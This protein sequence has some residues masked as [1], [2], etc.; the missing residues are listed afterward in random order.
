MT[1]RP[2]ACALALGLITGLAAPHADAQTRRATPAKSKPA[3]V[4]PACTDFYSHANAAWMLANPL[5]P[6]AGSISA[7]GQLGDRARAQQIALL[8]ASMQAPQNPLQTLLGDF[9][10]SGLNEP[11]VENDGANPIA[12]LLQRVDAIKRTA[13]IAP[14]IAALHQVGIP[15]AF[16]FG[17]DIDLQDLNR[18]IGYLSQ[19]GLGLPDPA[20]YTRTDAD[21]RALLAQ[22]NLYVQKIL[23][24][25]GVP[26]DKLAAQ[27][28][29]VIDLETR[30]AQVAK[31]LAQ[32][33]DPRANYAPVA[34]N[35]LDAQYRNLQLGQFLKVQ[36]LSYDSGADAVIS[37]S[38]PAVLAQ[39][40]G[41]V[42][43]LKPE[44][45]RAYLRWRIGDAMAP[46]LAK[47]WRDAHF[48]FRGRLLAGRAAPAP[49][50]QQVL[51]AINLAAGPM[52]GR[53]Y[54][55]SY[56]P[57]ATRARAQQIADHVRD[58][59]GAALQRDTRLGPQAKA[60]AQSKLSKLGIEI[61]A[62]ARDLD[63]TV[64]PM[65]RG[66]FGGNMLIASAWRHR[67]EMKRIGR[68]NADRRWDVLPQQPA[69]AYEVA[70]NRL[71]V[72]AAMLQPPVLDMLK[73]DAAQYGAF[74]ALV[75]HELSHGF[76]AR[77][78]MVDSS[79]TLRDW[80]SPADRGAWEAL[81]NRVTAQYG[82]QP[83]LAGAKPNGN[84]TRDEN[85]A[86]I[87]GVEL[88]WAAFRGVQPGADKPS[89][90][91][92]YEG[93]AHLWPQHMSP[94]AATLRAASGVHSP[95]IWRTNGPLLNQAGFGEAFSCKPGTPMQPKVDEQIALWR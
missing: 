24:L 92:F 2:L 18:H 33:R 49:R 91:A 50:Q 35:G 89:Q 65:G 28:Q 39:L 27:A 22:Y 1:L 47:A 53:E 75:G 94:E 95:A 56:L 36:G 46:Y 55:A 4:S 70:Q 43:T 72:T 25:T 12:P 13:H 32:L 6:G 80:W 23:A 40:D 69:L 60:E 66:S 83:A 15:V 16:N 86:D 78:R 90:Q 5:P 71:V 34:V 41:L 76:D 51:D 21:T 67:E 88:A 57:A 64:Q 10:A 61:G 20:Y 44:Q 45:W 52:L 58:A 19:G 62:P 63:F 68:G 77:G 79:G 9:W 37:I 54:A 3:Q 38:D 31:P 74:G 84:Q 82:A 87:A 30:L 42:K 17:A 81:A 14:A 93:W 8:N 11:G 59:L 73:Q 48:D 7:L 26:Q 85:I 29:S